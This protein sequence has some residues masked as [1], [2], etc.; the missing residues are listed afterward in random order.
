ML[1]VCLL[2]YD[3]SVM[4]ARVMNASVM[5]ASVLV[6]RAYSSICICT[7]VFRLTQWISHCKR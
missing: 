2:L 6:R 5:N 3:A 4:G 7:A 1:A